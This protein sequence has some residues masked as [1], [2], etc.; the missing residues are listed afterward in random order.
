MPLIRSN[1]RVRAASS[2]VFAAAPIFRLNVTSPATFVMACCAASVENL[3]T[4][5]TKSSSPCA[6]LSFP[7]LI[8]AERQ[9]RYG[10]DC[11]LPETSRQRGRMAIG[12]DAT[13]IG[14][15][16]ITAHCGGDADRNA[17]RFQEGSLFDMEFEKGCDEAGIEQG[18]DT[19]VRSRISQVLDVMSQR[20]SA[21][22]SD[23]IVDLIHCRQSE[24]EPTAE[25]G[26]PEPGALLAPHG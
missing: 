18:R 7:V 26:S 19:P 3:P 11:V 14:K 25:I 21:V 20:F 10:K 13:R 6:I 1:R 12:A 23:E 5:K 24:H 17:V 16:D 4:V 9:L 2:E 22:G 15:A 8:E